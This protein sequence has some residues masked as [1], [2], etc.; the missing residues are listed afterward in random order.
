MATKKISVSP[1]DA[2]EKYIDEK[3]KEVKDK[4]TPGAS[5]FKGSILADLAEAGLR[6][7]ALE[8]SLASARAELR[9]TNVELERALTDLG[10]VRAELL[11]HQDRAR[12]TQ[13]A[14]KDAQAAL[15]VEGRL[16]EELGAARREREAMAAS[17]EAVQRRYQELVAQIKGLARKCDGAPP[18]AQGTLFPTPPP[19]PARRG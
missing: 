5:Y 13:S 12:R 19:G 10:G 15:A 11:A 17:L 7:P 16:R 8:T 4:A 14:T 18:A 3:A 1:S 6:V 9:C 2:L